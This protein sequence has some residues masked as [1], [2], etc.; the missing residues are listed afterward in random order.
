M[1]IGTRKLLW[2]N[3]GNYDHILYIEDAFADTYFQFPLHI[4]FLDV[5][6]SF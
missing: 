3:L 5:L 4:R 6:Q 1:V 2:Y